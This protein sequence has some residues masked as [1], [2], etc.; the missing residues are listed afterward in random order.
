ML[1]LHDVH[2]YY[3]PV[4]VLHGITLEVREGEIVSLLGSNAAG[5]ST[6]LKTIFGVVRPARG[7][8]EFRGER[9]DGLSPESISRRRIA[10][11]PEGRRIFP[12]MSIREN[13]EM[14]AYV[15]SDH[16]AVAEDLDRVLTMFPRLKER[17]NQK[18]GTLSGGEQQMLAIG[19]A[20]M[21]RPV[22]V[23]LDEPSMGLSPL[24]VERVFETIQKI[25]TEG[26]TVF[27]VEQNAQMALSISSRG[28]VLETGTLALQGNRDELLNNAQMK[29]AYLG[30]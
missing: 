15:R 16:V 25:N 14:G 28:Y 18:G 13:L 23:C 10:L 17:I 5:K 7:T 8:V 29:R 6:T 24:L 11:V 4:R 12:R 22:L 1:Q 19:R 21:A 9:I 2:A 30:T 26:V 3:G 27:M 20:L